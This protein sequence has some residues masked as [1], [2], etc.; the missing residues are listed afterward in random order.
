M[1][2][3]EPKSLG[4]FHMYRRYGL[5]GSGLWDYVSV[6]CGSLLL[7]GDPGSL[8][9]RFTVSP[10]IAASTHHPLAVVIQTVCMCMRNPSSGT[11][12][13]QWT[14]VAEQLCLQL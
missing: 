9:R 7:T 1:D 10:T 4:G 8:Y 6:T 13:C 2:E 3:H 11:V 12:G 14:G 5:T